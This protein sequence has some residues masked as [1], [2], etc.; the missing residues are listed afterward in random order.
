MALLMACG[1]ALR[2]SHH[3]SEDVAPLDEQPYRKKN[4]EMPKG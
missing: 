1:G 3:A 2:P 4:G